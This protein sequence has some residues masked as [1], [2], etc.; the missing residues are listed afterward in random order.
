[1]MKIKC[2][3]VE[4][5]KPAKKSVAKKLRTVKSAVKRANKPAPWKSQA[6]NDDSSSAQFTPKV[7]TQRGQETSTTKVT[8]PQA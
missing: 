5:E 2:Y 6:A 8:A 4:E 7:K 3:E 1:M